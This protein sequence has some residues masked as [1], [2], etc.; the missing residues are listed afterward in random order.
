[1]MNDDRLEIRTLG[2][3]RILKARNSSNPSRKICT[4]TV[5]TESHIS[6]DADGYIDMF[7]WPTWVPSEPALTKH[8]TNDQIAERIKTGEPGDFV[9]EF[10]YHTQAVE[11][12]VEMV[13]EAAASI[14]GEDARH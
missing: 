13:T 6:L 12:A 5:P 10:P 14:C 11:R 7:E 4:F 8:L 1:M 3:R 9:E 2:S